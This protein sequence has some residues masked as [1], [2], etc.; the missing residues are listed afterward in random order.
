MPETRDGRFK[1]ELAL[2]GTA[3][4]DVQAMVGSLVGYAMASVQEPATVYKVGEH[5]VSLLMSVGDLLIGYLLLRQAVVAQAALDDGASPKDTDFYAGKLAVAHWF[6]RNVLPELTTRR[7]IIEGADGSLMEV[8][9]AA[10]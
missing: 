6:A 1:E 9:E 3:L 4:A 7:G 2:L 10:F 5:A 8:A